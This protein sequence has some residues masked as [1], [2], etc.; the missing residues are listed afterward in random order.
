VLEAAWKEAEEIARIADDLLIP[1]WI[2]DR[3]GR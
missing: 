3:I 2:R 1:E